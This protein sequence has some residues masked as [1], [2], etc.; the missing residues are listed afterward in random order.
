[1]IKFIQT[2]D[3]HLGLEPDKGS[4]WS[5]KRKKDIFR[6]FVNVVEQ[7]KKEQAD[8]LLIPGDL[9]HRAAP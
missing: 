2:A 9:F 5:E 4:P 1:M 7:V 3:I 8:L 6:S